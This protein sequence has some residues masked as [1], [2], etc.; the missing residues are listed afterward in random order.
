MPTA[1]TVSR[2][3][4]RAACAAALLSGAMAAHAAASK[5]DL[6]LTGAKPDRL[7]VIDAASR[8]VRAEHR[9][10]GAEGQIFTILVSPDQRTAYLLVARMER[11]VGVDI[12]SGREVFRA[13]LSSSRERVKDFFAMTLSHD[14]KELIAYEMP[15]RLEPSEYVVEEPRFAVFRT[16]AGLAASPVR[17]FPAP[18]RIHMLLSRPSGKSFYALGFDLYEYGWH[19]GKLLGTRGVQKWDIPA[20]SQPDLLA[21]WPVTEPTGVFTSPIYTEVKQGADSVPTTAL[22]SL[23]LRSGDLSYHDFEPL[24][25]LIFSTVLSPDKKHAYG[26]YTQ[27]TSIDVR[28]SRLEKRVPLDHTFYD[29]NV[30]SDG[31]EIYLGGTN[32]DVA[33]YDA[34]SLAKKAVLKLP[35]CTDQ[36][37]STLRV[38][39]GQ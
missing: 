29:I 19:D 14:G 2:R 26:V 33:F 38:V 13:D 12:A 1:S 37:L 23:D 17:T 15:T 39:H 27:L 4:R 20:H 28:G 32:C 30:S 9:V 35:G 5:P 24:S 11:I 16:D 21:F 7:F 31:R 34:S 6:L 22:M 36:A 8:S 18:R 3:L 25:A 10:E